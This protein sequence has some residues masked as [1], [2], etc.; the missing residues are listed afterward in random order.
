M[1][2]KT[3]SHTRFL[4]LSVMVSCLCASAA[5]AM[6][7]NGNNA[8]PA[9]N[10]TADH[11]TYDDASQQVVAAGNVSFEQAGKIVTAQRV[12][13][14]LVQDVVLAEGDVVLTETNGDVHFAEKVE[15]TDDLKDGFVATL[16]ST[17]ADGSRFSAKSGQRE[18]GTK[19]V[20]QEAS[21]TP[22]EPCKLDP[23]KPPLW[24]LKADKVTHDN[25]DKSISYENATFELGGVP[26]L[27]TPY[28]SHPDGQ[29]KQKSG[30]LT[31][32]FA[33]SSDLGFSVENHYYIAI[34]PTAD[35]TVGARVFTEE[36]PLGTLDLRKRFDNAMVQAQTSFTHSERPARSDGE[37][38]TKGSQARGHIFAD[39]VWNIDDKWRAGFDMELA[40]DD[41]YLR[42]Y[43]ISS[44]RV[45]E[46]EIYAERFSGRDYTAVRALAFQDIR[47][48]ADQIDQPNI[49]PEFEMSFIGEPNDTL[50]GRWNSNT[51]FLGLYRSGEAAQ[52]VFRL[53]QELG[54]EGQHISD[55]GLVN[56]LTASV[57][58]DGYIVD[59]EGLP[60]DEETTDMVGRAYASTTL[61]SRMPF[62]KTM[63]TGALRIE[64]MASLTLSPDLDDEDIP[65]EDSQ[66]AQIDISN[67][68]EPNRFPGLDRIEDSTHATYG[69]R[70]GYYDANGS[71]GEVFLGQSYRFDDNPLFPPGS[72]LEDR[73]SDLVGQISGR[74]MDDVMMFY[75]FQAD[76]GSGQV[77]RHEFDATINTDPVILNTTYLYARALGGTELTDSREQVSSLASFKLAEDWRMRVGG[78]YDF[79][80]DEGLRKALMG[81]DYLGQCLTLSL[82]GERTLTV[83]E[84]GESDTEFFLRVGLK[85]LGEFGSESTIS[86]YD[87]RED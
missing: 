52:D 44:E 57:R 35:A 51:S 24:Q 15:F 14:N 2:P 81:L 22:C 8:D 65:N 18:G 29:E 6:P 84:T 55:F 68:F 42:Q 25:A 34:S 75:K 87:T 66:D 71:L 40:S 86:M 10:F 21:Y 5:W 37:V 16:R 28:F 30:F 85:N 19:I 54:W 38:I 64:P 62:E 9:V 50:G 73:K 56:T 26:V 78:I 43:D 67:L 12:T 83:P 32:S 63:E 46:N 20:M 72:G 80:E 59:D 69:V 77:K 13:Y 11:L 79:G 7:G 1:M 47:V 60:A 49:V 61:E 3:F 23:S 36:T 27:Y 58:G 76:A 4:C 39:G 17:L 45:L 41:Q 33:L 74:Y 82:T 48:N 70:T 31:P 53:S